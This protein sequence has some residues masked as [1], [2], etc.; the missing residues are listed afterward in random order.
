MLGSR[1]HQVGGSSGEPNVRMAAILFPESESPKGNRL[2]RG[3]GTGRK[4]RRPTL[5]FVGRDTS[6]LL[7]TVGA[8]KRRPRDV[9]AIRAQEGED[10]FS[11]EG[12]ELTTPFSRKRLEGHVLREPGHLVEGGLVVPD[13]HRWRERPPLTAVIEESAPSSSPRLGA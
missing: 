1:D 6:G 10:L 12:G 5:S 2:P 4:L 11:K 3:G 8:I 7:Y 13:E 9:F